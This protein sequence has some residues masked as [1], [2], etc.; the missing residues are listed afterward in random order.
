MWSCLTGLKML[1]GFSR[2]RR[3]AL[4]RPRHGAMRA[5]IGTW[6]GDM[7]RDGRGWIPGHSP[8]TDW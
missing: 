1:Y 3:Y 5:Q 2:A 8:L 6:V 4:P 7:P